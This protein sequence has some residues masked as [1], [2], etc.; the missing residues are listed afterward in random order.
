VSTDYVG[1]GLIALTF[2]AF[3]IML[4]RGEDDDWF[5]SP[6]IGSLAVIAAAGAA[7]AVAWLLYTRRPVV[8]LRVFKDR[9]FTLG[10][11]AI[12]TFAVL[13]YGS[14]VLVPQLAQQHLG[15]TA[16]LAG[17]VMSP[18]AVCVIF[19]IPLLNL[20][21][22]RVQTRF[23]LTFGFLVLGCSMLYSRTL[24]PDI[25]FR[26]LMFMRITQSL[27]I[28]FLFVPL[29]I[30]A[31]GTL[32]RDLQQDA[33]ALFTMFRNVLG[34]VGISVAT[35]MITSRTQTHMAY[36]GYHTSQT[37]PNFREHLAQVSRAIQ[38]LGASASVAAQKAFGHAYQTFIAQASFLAYKDVFLYCALL[39][40]VFTPLTFFFSGVKKAGGPPG[41]H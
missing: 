15:Y 27:G 37:N 13:L 31:Y 5:S 18:G 21:L 16:L 32:P 23:I 8:D 9:N 22:P 36:L 4:D 17:L 39:A 29:S 38:G 34:S 1:I 11:I 20:V 25:D 14:A 33:T 2:A 24:A 30:L 7:T 3:Q 6:F 26:H 12:G 28:G 41:A 35:A 40:F 10:C 19:L